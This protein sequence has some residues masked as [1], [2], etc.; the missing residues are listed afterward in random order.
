MGRL[1]ATCTSYELALVAWAECDDCD[2]GAMVLP[3]V[4]LAKFLAALPAGGIVQLS[5]INE[6]NAVLECGQVRAELSGVDV[7][8]WPEGATI[9][10][11]GT[12]FELPRE[13][14]AIG[15]KATLPFTSDDAN[16][17]A[18]YAICLDI[19]RDRITFAST[20]GTRLSRYCR[21]HM[22][23]RAGESR[24]LIP[25]H[26]G[27]ELLDNL[28]RYPDARVLLTADDR[29][30]TAHVGPATVQGRAVEERFPEY[31]RVIPERD[32]EYTVAVEIAKIAESV[33]RC[34][35]ICDI[36]KDSTRKVK[37][38]MKGK[39]VT[40]SAEGSTGSV[41]DA[42]DLG[43]LFGRRADVGVAVGVDPSKLREA[44]AIFAA[45]YVNVQ[46]T[47]Q[48]SAML[49]D[50]DEIPGLIHVLMPMRL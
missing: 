19:G 32:R 28:K 1:V 14:L 24:Y 44:L 11:K 10:E 7:R 2:D 15:L 45:S 29:T 40:V 9:E 47:D 6:H 38:A 37:V 4:P 35:T 33:A 12:P 26:M 30:L 49:F 8:E 18:L 39:Q 25:A 34:A 23:G 13:A 21:E 46:I 16:R 22:T 50:S 41:H 42:F 20:D 31:T 43:E 36:A 17:P 3:A 27:R 48:F 5:T